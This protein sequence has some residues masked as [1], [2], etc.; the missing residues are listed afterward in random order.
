MFFFLKSKK[1]PNI[2]RMSEKYYTT[3]ENLRHT[4]DTFGVAIIPNV[5]SEIECDAFMNETWDYF[6]HITKDWTVPIMRNDT[7]TYRSIY[8]L[9]PSHSMLF[10]HF[11]VGH[12]QSVWNIR[13]N[14]KV[15][16]IQRKF[17]NTDELSVSFDGLSFAIP[18][19]ITKR[20]FYRNHSWLHCDQSFTRNEFECL[21]SWVT[22]NDVDEGDA[23]LVILERSNRYHVEFKETFNISDKKDWFKLNEEQIHF[24][25]DP[26]RNCELVKIKCPKGSIVYWD[27]RTIHFGCESMK[28]RANPHYRCVAYLCYVPKSLVSPSIQRKKIK[29]FEEKRTTTHNPIKPRLFGKQPQTY[30]KVLNDTTPVETPILTELGRSLI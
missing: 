21:Q 19:E 26:P 6:E 29:A 5:L 18:H 16:E 23:T 7:T 22:A 10:Q 8:E 2:F 28:I 27:S 25:T 1:T 9:Y 11:G 3:S 13:Q 24:Y 4:I 14:P 17:W 20:G 30:G 15:V 12:S